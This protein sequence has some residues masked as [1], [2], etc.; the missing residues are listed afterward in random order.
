MEQ[1]ETAGNARIVQGVLA[2]VAVVF[3]VVTIFAGARVLFGADPGYVVFR[4]LLI[5]NTGMGFVYLI[6]GLLAWRCL[7]CGRRVAAAIFV[8]NLLVLAAIAAL[9]A[10]GSAV[11]TQSLAAM[12]FRAVVWLLLFA[13]LAWV[14]RRR[15]RQNPAAVR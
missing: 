5:Y 1:N 4:P 10:G 2:G 8:L 15:A 7:A 3:G 14:S 9:H 6:A 12:G 11:A 13:G